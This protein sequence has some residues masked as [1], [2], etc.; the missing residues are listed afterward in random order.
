MMNLSGKVL[1]ILEV[2]PEDL[3][4]VCDDVNLPLG[5]IRLRAKGGPGGHNGLESCV[6][7]MGT[8]E[9]GRLRIGVGVKALPH[10]LH[11]FVLS[12]FDR[13]EEPVVEEA[14][15][16][17]IEACGCWVEEGMDRAMSRYNRVEE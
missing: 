6:A 16:K 11:D 1:K 4:V 13:I 2:A 14:I 9:I 12:A 8:E 10:E 17:A 3:L 15:Q 5:R 7:A